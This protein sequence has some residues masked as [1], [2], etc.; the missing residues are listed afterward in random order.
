MGRVARIKYPNQIYSVVTRVN[1]SE[2]M[3]NQNLV[4]E[5][6]LEH[7]KVLKQKLDFKLF[8]FIIMSTHV[9][10]L[11]KPNDEISD[12]SHIMRHINGGFAQKFNMFNKRKG[13]FWLE[14]FKSKIVEPGQY[15]ANTVI[16]FA[17][18]PI[19]A[20]ITD[21]PLKFKYSSIHNI[22]DTNKF[23]DILDPLPESLQQVLKEFIKRERFVE[24]VERTVR[25]AKK[26]SFNL[27]KSWL[28]QRHR[29]FVGSSNFIKNNIINTFGLQI[30]QEKNI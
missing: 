16:Y 8:A 2:F 4:A 5:T 10:L 24:L 27:R 3:F 1:N 18:N 6:F 11:I 19:K 12:I 14:R 7:L 15:L 26:F 25:F 20:G 23:G 13:H 22:V 21:N 9:H 17:L 28:E 30:N 29:H